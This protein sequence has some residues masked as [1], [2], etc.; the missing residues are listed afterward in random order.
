MELDILFV[1]PNAK[2]ENYGPLAS[3]FAGIEPPVW[4]GL[5][6]AYAREKGLKVG[7]IDAEVENISPQQ[8]AEK[9]SRLKPL[10]VDIVVMGINPSASSTPKMG[11]VEEI[12]ERLN[13]IDPDLKT[14]LTGIHPSA[15][16]EQTL[17]QEGVD[18]I[19]QGESFE[20]IYKLAETI[21]SGENNYNING[22]WYKENSK[23]KSNLPPSIIKNIDELPFVAWDLLPMDKYRAHN[24]HCLHDLDNRSPYAAIYTSLGCPFNCTYCNIHSM[25]DG[26][27]GIR[28]RNPKIVVDELELLNKKYRVKNIKILDELFVLKEDRVT[29]ICDMINERNLEFN[30]WAYSRI[31]TVNKRILKKMKSAGINWLCYGIES[32]SQKVRKDVHKSQFGRELIKTAIKMTHDAGIYVIGNFMFGL[33]EDDM[34]TMQE[35]LNLAKELNC[36]YVNFY[37]VMAYPGSQLFEEAKRK[38]IRLPDSW[39]GY[40][41]LSRETT[42]LPNKYLTSEQILEF[43]DKA[44]NEYFSNP[45]YLEMINEK[46]GKKA[47]EHI[48]KMLMH[49]LERDI[50][51]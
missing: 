34:E 43:R 41:Q 44:F 11:A 1:N 31:D 35:T 8:T 4:C 17:Q 42:P 36:E 50:L 46:F 51:R 27:P 14:V 15:L 32:G 7:I 6:A 29:Q 23:I 40:S 33:P 19:A 38:R 37:T 10:L 26:K 18:F 24:W 5:K 25:Y 2:K 48:K 49:K 3:E 28:Y 9:I 47:V 12:I 30:I 21:K 39:L 13:K 20:S 22:I 45:E 16:P